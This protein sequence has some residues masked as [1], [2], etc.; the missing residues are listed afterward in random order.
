MFKN[1]YFKIHILK[2]IG[3]RKF[4]PLVLS[5]DKTLQS[6][7][8]IKNYSRYQKKAKPNSLPCFLIATGIFIKIIISNIPKPTITISTIDT[9]MLSSIIFH[10]TIPFS[11]P[12]LMA[13]LAF[14]GSS[15]RGVSLSFGHPS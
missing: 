10:Y 2:C 13:E 7:L 5:K 15:L 8:F 11:S 6:F 1:L 14:S 4:L 9:P 12:P 3:P